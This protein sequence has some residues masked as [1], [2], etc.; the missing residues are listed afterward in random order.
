MVIIN[1]LPVDMLYEITQYLT[2][3][4][5]CTMRKTSSVLNYKINCIQNSILNNE[6]RRSGKSYGVTN[7]NYLQS[8]FYSFINYHLVT[9]LYKFRKNNL[10]YNNAQYLRSY[11]MCY[12]YTSYRLNFVDGITGNPTVNLLFDKI[13]YYYVYTN[14]VHISTY[15]NKL[16]LCALYNLL[17]IEIFQ[18]KNDFNYWVD[19]LESLN[20]NVYSD[21]IFRY[22]SST[23]DI[24][25]VGTNLH[26]TFDQ[27]YKM[28]SVIT[29]I[30]V[31]KQI[32][33][34]RVLDLSRSSLNV[35]C[36]DCNEPNLFEICDLKMTH[37]KDDLISYN[38]LQLKDL[39]KREN[40]YYYTMLTNRETFLVNT[41]IYV[42]NPITN[43]R[44]RVNGNLYKQFM[45]SMESD[46]HLNK[47]YVTIL[48]YI[49][50][51]QHFLKQRYFT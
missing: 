4:D 1:D 36:V 14:Y 6:L 31:I 8:L 22:Y 51:Q 18:N 3:R 17:Q 35:C 23:L 45:R 26:L 29:S 11:I 39:L 9:F 48:R 46:K 40:I 5:I 15:P 7:F 30:P 50:K 12:S 38:Y 43:R 49:Y 10:S 16:E 37:Y 41:M 24:Y 33:G 47:Y 21:V 2:L 20:K 44:M 28:S 27:M 25:H 42:K 13:F 34:Y 32:I 19:F